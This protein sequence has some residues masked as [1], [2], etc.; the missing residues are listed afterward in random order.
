MKKKSPTAE[1]PAAFSKFHPNLQRAALAA[2]HIEDASLASVIKALEFARRSDADLFGLGRGTS[3]DHCLTMTLIAVRGWAR[4]N[5]PGCN[6][7]SLADFRR[8]KQAR[9]STV[10]L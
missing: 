4:I 7:V 5:R 6:V 9:A 8:A 3:V 1:P 2:T 10:H